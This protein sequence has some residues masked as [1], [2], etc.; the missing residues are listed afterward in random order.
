VIAGMVRTARSDEYDG[1]SWWK[2]VSE[3]RLSVPLSYLYNAR[4]DDCQRVDRMADSTGIKYEAL[5]KVD[6]IK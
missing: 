4:G 5:F 3:E 2:V 1:G 6:E